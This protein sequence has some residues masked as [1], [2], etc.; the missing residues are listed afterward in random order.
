MKWML[1][2]GAMALALGAA[3]CAT[4]GSSSGGSGGSKAAC[5]TRAT[6]S[7]TPHVG[8]SG[9]VRVDALV[10]HLT[11][12]RTAKA[13]GN[14]QFGLGAK[15]N[16][17]FVI[18]KL[19]VHSDK[20]QSAT[21]T[22]DAVK[23]EVRGNTYDADSDGTVAAM[24]AGEQPFLVDTIGPDSDR[25]GTVVFDVPPRVLREGPE[26]RFNELG[27][28]STHDCG[29]QT[30]TLDKNACQAGTGIGVALILL[31]GFFGFVFLSFIWL[32]SRPRRRQCPR[33]GESVKK[34]LVQCPSCSYDFGAIGTPVP[35][36]VTAPP[37]DVP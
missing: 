18:V 29:S 3:G 30:T 26:L 5:G 36:G 17:V 28:G 13:I 27:F 10:W 34:G 20:N 2:A 22:D 14:Q 21:L 37:A 8:S 23:L 9:H 4:T 24:G 32:M 11:S 6:D 31:I 25:N 16:G 35:A 7:C 1:C 19:R 15:A 33:C 12:A